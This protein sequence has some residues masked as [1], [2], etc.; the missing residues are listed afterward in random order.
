MF[1]VLYRI[2]YLKNYDLKHV[3]KQCDKSTKKYDLRMIE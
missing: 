2:E 1:A 3:F